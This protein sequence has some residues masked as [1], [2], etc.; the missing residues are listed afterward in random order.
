[1]NSCL[2][3]FKEPQLNTNILSSN[4]ML[5]SP[6]TSLNDRNTMEF[7]ISSLSDLYLD[8]ASTALRIKF[9]IVHKNGDHLKSYDEAETENNRTGIE[10]CF[11]HSLI[12]QVHI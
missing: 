9:Q 11:L 3:V 8:L 4:E 10:N 6:I 12:K 5:F 1:M 2:D 7:Q